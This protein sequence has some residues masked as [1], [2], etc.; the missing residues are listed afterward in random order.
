MNQDY[1]SVEQNSDGIDLIEIGLRIWSKRIFIIKVTA[2]FIVIGVLVAFLS[3]VKFRSE[4]V[5]VLQSSQGSS[6]GGMGSLA[7]LA[8]ISLGDM[9]GGSEML[10]PLVYSNVLKNI[11]FQKE[12]INTPF[13]F[14]EYG[15]PT[16]LFEDYLYIK[17]NRSPLLKYTVGLPGT[18]LKAIK[19]DKPDVVSSADSPI[20]YYSK[21]EYEFLKEFSNYISL[22]VNDKDGYITISSTMPE[23][24]LAAEVTLRVQDMLQRY[25]TEFKIGKAKQS[26]DFIL[27]RYEEA[28]I[29]FE[30]KQLAYALFS[31]ANKILTSANARIT[32]EK[33]RTAYD[34]ASAT[35]RELAT[36]LIQAEIKLKEDAPIFTVIEPVK[37][38]NLRSEP[39]RVMILIAFTFIGV[40]IASCLVLLFDNLKAKGLD[41]KFLNRW[42]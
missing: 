20:Q 16:T 29:D 12:L 19:G 32:D 1:C 27:E 17:E 26:Y 13:S 18:I 5:F 28:K 39:K 37:I 31:D 34:M 14:S 30:E 15:E 25:I 8:G 36:Q 2:I 22:N 7:Q 11:N 33:L 42:S 40:V 10:S 21:D 38:P 9:S 35:Y 24:L 23:P 3:P 4:S 41:I 6:S